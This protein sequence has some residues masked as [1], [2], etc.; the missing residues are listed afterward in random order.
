MIFARPAHKVAGGVQEG[1]CGGCAGLP[2]QE[3]D[4][5]VWDLGQM[6]LRVFLVNKSEVSLDKCDF[7]KAVPTNWLV[8]EE[9]R[10]ESAEAEQ[11]GLPLQEADAGVWDLGQLCFWGPAGWY[12]AEVSGTWGRCVLFLRAGCFCRK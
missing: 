6:C 9:G 1:E 8:V 5:G 7:C 2:L 11:E 12:E 10:R 4:A 3:G